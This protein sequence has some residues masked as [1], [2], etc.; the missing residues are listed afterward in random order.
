MSEV[1]YLLL[2]RAPDEPAY[3]GLWQVV[4]GSIEPGEK[5]IDAA[6][7][8]LREETGVR[9]EH[10]W[11]VPYTNSFYD[12]RL[13][14]INLIPFFAAQFAPGDNPRLSA[15]HSE[16]SW[17]SHRDAR[18]CLVWPGQKAGLDVVH[19]S[20]VEGQPAARLTEVPL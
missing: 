3:P 18:A 4:T 5:A 12:H 11:V 10:F 1:V 13:D 9:P 20:I 19:S 14:C 2:R 8:E 7:R 15:E 16:S 17:L 6:L